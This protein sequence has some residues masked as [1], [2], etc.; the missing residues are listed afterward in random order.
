[1]K[2]KM[3]VLEKRLFDFLRRNT[4]EWFTAK[5]LWIHNFAITQRGVRSIIQNLRLV[6][7]KTIASSH[8]GYCYTSKKEPLKRPL[9]LFVDMLYWN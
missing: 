9:A 1:M 4:N 3:T 5:I 7:G 2:P 8:L 6:H